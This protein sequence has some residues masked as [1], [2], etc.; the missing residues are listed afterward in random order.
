[1]STPTAVALF[2][3]VAILAFLAGAFVGA[4]YQSVRQDQRRPAQPPA[5]PDTGQ[6][7]ELDRLIE[8]GFTPERAQWIRTMFAPEPCE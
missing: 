8:G 3:V 7:R 4:A 5:A 1:M 2:V 6:Q